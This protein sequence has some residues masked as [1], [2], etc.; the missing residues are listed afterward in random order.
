[1]EIDVEGGCRCGAVR[2]RVRGFVLASGICHCRTCR[3]TASAPSLPFATIAAASFRLIH[4]CPVEQRSS[5]H[6]RRGFCGA[7]GSP[8]TW[9]HDA[10]P[11]RLDV[12]ICSLDDPAAVPPTFHVWTSH[13]PAWS[14]VADGLPRFA[15]ARPTTGS[16]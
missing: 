16:G 2:Y 4:G 15:T 9:R 3:R 6:V 13:A 7:C 5:E 11:G 1:M 12:M 14:I 10:K 8:L